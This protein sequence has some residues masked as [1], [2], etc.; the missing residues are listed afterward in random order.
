MNPSNTA[1]MRASDD[2][3]F[4]DAQIPIEEIVSQTYASVRPEV[5]SW[6]LTRLVAKVYASAPAAVQSSLLAQLLRPLGILSLLALAGGIFAKMRFHCASPGI[7][8]VLEDAR[9][10]RIG[11]LLILVDHA[12]QVS[13]QALDGLA[14]I[15]TASALMT[16]SAAAAVLVTVLAARASERRSSDGEFDR[17]AAKS[18]SNV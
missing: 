14:Q 4:S 18:R 2:L 11:D 15:I 12:Q 5:R 10:V 7:H 8:V 6:M 13:G 9:H 3:C 16:T 17:P 1:R